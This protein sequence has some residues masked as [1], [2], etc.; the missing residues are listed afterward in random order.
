MCCC[1]WS[2]GDGT[3]SQARGE[4]EGRFEPLNAEQAGI[5]RTCVGVLLYLSADVLEAQYSIAFAKDVHA[6]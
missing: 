1:Q 6:N 2:I 3:S 4:D 5:Y